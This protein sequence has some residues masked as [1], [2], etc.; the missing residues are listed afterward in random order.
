MTRVTHQL[1]G[2]VDT[3]AALMTDPAFLDRKFV[4]PLR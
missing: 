3:V 4:G 2:D 1:G